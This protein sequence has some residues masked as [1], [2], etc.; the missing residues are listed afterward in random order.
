M[1]VNAGLALA[2]SGLVAAT[3]A[4]D[5]L[6]IPYNAYQK[7]FKEDDV[8]DD[9]KE[10]KKISRQKSKNRTNSICDSNKRNQK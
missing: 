2:K 6:I 9:T 4:G 5:V 8:K 7:N 10:N 3:T 1:G